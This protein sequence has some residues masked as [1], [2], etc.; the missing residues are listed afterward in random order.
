MLKRRLRKYL[1]IYLDVE[2]VIKSESGSTARG[3][4]FR[5]YILSKL[6]VSI[7]SQL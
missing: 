6:E 7:G 3:E 1:D 4:A 5:V 2:L